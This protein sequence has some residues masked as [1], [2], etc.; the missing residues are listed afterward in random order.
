[1]ATLALS[2]I[3]T[4]LGGP[5]GGAIGSLIGQGIDQQLFGPGPRHG[6]RLGDLSIQTSTYGSQIPRVYGTMRVAGTVI[7]ATELKE[8]SQVQ[9]GAKGQPGVV[10]YSYSASFAVALSSRG[11]REIRRIWADGKLLR[12]AAGD[13]KVKTGFRFYPG[14]E[15]QEIDPRIAEV[16][17]IDRT[18]AYRGLAIAV[19][20]DLELAEYGNRIPQ[21]TFEIVADEA[22][23]SVSTILAD[24]T[25]GLIAAASPETVMGYAAHGRDRRSALAPLIEQF[26]VPLVDDGEQL[27]TAD[28]SAIDGVPDDALGCGVGTEAQP[29]IERS[30]SPARTLPKSL[31]LSYY[32]PQRDY[33]AGQMRASAAS[34]GGVEEAVELAAALTADRAKALAE[35]RIAMRWAQRDTITLRLPPDRLELAPGNL[36]RLRD[37]TLCAVESATLEEMVV[38]VGLRPVWGSVAASAA[39]P[40]THLPAPDIVVAPTSVALFDLPDL[41]IG[42]EGAPALHAA[43]CQPMGGWRP[44]P[45][46]VTVGGGETR[47]ITSA[48]SEAVLGRALSVLADGQAALLDLKNSMEVELHDAGHWLESRDD[49]A[50]ANGANLAVLGDELIQFGLAEPLGARRFRLSR[51]LRGRRGTEWAMGAH[52]AGEAFVLIDANAM[53]PVELALEALGAEIAVRPAGLADADAVP[54]R[55]TVTGEALRPPSPVHLKAEIMAAGVQ[56]RWVRRSRAGWAWLDGMDSPLGESLERY[57][58]RVTGSADS[59]TIETGTADVTLTAAQLSVLGAGVATISVTQLGDTSESRPAS[60][61]INLT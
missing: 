40:G 48:R 50:L 56:V 27:A 3:G 8:S 22:D 18:P 11:A 34:S 15:D 14:S 9:G 33:Q 43:A 38:R 53:Q 28:E 37:G 42:R 59:L 13:F 6:P 54:A 36:L 35:S 17:G 24:A 25:D 26:A 46:E 39:D 57:R 47:T 51:L 60:T 16:E 23:P 21:P 5:I 7:W 20:E 2:S 29:M 49:E 1:M 30:Q 31:T 45:L 55:R 58:V 52:H 44:A 32:D 10:I 41:G 12:G 19:F 4:A 61:T